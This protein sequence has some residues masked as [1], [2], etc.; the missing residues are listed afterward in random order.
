MTHH[1]ILL[2]AIA[3]PVLFAVILGVAACWT[4]APRRYSLPHH[5]RSGDTTPVP[6]G[7]LQAYGLK[8]GYR[9]DPDSPTGTLLTA[10]GLD[11][12]EQP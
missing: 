5:T 3:V 1:L 6:D 2:A 12:G 11:E 7:L 4:P 10:Y 9:I 8:L